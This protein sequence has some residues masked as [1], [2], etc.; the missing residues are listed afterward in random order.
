MPDEDKPVRFDAR[1]IAVTVP[2]WVEVARDGAATFLIDGK[3]F[4]AQE[5][6]WL[7]LEVPVTFRVGPEIEG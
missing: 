6:T 3:R 2:I 4:T 5:M 1:A 7:E